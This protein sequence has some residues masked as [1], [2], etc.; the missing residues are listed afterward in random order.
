M[1]ENRDPQMALQELATVLQLAPDHAEAKSLKRA[2]CDE[3]GRPDPQDSPLQD[4]DTDAFPKRQDTIEHW[5][6]II[7]EDPNNV[8]ALISRA[9]KLLGF[10]ELSS[11][12]A[13]IEQALELSP[14]NL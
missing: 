6:R 10:G 12:L 11:S 13:D 2:I 4:E 7:E 5:S 1:E 8:D 9:N 14:E 3:L